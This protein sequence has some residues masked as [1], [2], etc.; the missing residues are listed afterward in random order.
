MPVIKQGGYWIVQGVG[1]KH[2]TKKEAEAQMRAV[3]A[4]QSRAKKRKS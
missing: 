1:D 2:A 4:S 3:K